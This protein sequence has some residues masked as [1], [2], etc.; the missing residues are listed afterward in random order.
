MGGKMARRLHK[1]GFRGVAY[2]R[3]RDKT[4]ETLDEFAPLLAAG[5]TVVDGGAGLCRKHS[6]STCPPGSSSCR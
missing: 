2:N 5:D 1:A 6:T 3:H 4:E